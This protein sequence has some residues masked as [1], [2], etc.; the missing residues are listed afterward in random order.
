MLVEGWEGSDEEPDGSLFADISTKSW[1]ATSVE[2]LK[3]IR[4][5]RTSAKRRS[6][7]SKALAEGR[8]RGVREGAGVSSSRALRDVNGEDV[9][10][11]RPARLR[12]PHQTKL[13]HDS[14]VTNLLS[15]GVTIPVNLI[16]EVEHDCTLRNTVSST[17]D[18][19]FVDRNLVVRRRWLDRLADLDISVITLTGLRDIDRGDV[20]FRYPRFMT[21]QAN[22]RIN[23]TKR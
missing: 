20:G 6:S 16:P 17:I 18:E 1:K 13:I 21:L 4:C 14:A 2:I 23:R 10:L 9:M 15:R 5:V 12:G 8:A 19:D 3:A 22:E 11:S 7:V